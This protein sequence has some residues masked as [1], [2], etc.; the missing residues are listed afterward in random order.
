M[1]NNIIDHI[2]KCLGVGP[3]TETIME[4]ASSAAIR[5]GLFSDN[6]PAE[7]VQEEKAQ[8]QQ[9]NCTIS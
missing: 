7:E 6:T 4:Q 3:L 2:D 5:F 8:R 1:P 9:L